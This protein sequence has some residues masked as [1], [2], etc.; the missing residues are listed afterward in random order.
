MFLFK[1]SNINLALEYSFNL[2]ITK[3]TKK[4]CMLINAFVED[5][6]YFD[7]RE[8]L[9]DLQLFLYKLTVVFRYV[10]IICFTRANCDVRLNACQVGLSNYNV[11]DQVKK[12]SNLAF[13]LL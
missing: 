6:L 5:R 7:L 8:V 2:K 11:E 9:I 12:R 3:A 4:P 1:L 13:I 10:S